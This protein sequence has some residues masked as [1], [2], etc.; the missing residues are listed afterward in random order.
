ME[1]YNH[2]SR[3]N[4]KL[5]NTLY[6]EFR[7][8]YG[9]N[10]QRERI[11]IDKLKFPEPRLLDLGVGLNYSKGWINADFFVGFRTTLSR[12]KSGQQLN[13]IELDL[14]YPI[15]CD[16]NII[17]GVYLSHTLEH[18]T[19][20]ES[21][22][23]LKEI[24][25]IMKPGCWVRIGV[26]DLEK[27]VKYY[28][29]KPS[30]KEFDKYKNGCIA[31][32]AITQDYG[33]YSAWDYSLLTEALSKSGY[34]NIKKVEFGEEGTDKRLIKEEDVRKWETLMIEAQKPE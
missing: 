13:E 11:K 18:L 9:R 22:N 1:K 28:I 19:P 4:S 12:K 15:K 21:V 32:S 6:F 16:S 14:R 3:V 2:F 24:A 26:P 7:S 25:R 30:A 17:D 10:I 5:I 29:G 27:Y 34:V 8:W 20:L 23:L 33:H 31:I